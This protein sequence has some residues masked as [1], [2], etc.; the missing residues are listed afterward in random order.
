MLTQSLRDLET[1][2]EKA[3]LSTPPTDDN[4]NLLMTQMMYTPKK[5]KMRHFGTGENE[6]EEIDNINNSDIDNEI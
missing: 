4:A 5:L 3:T 2:I 6:N 1:F